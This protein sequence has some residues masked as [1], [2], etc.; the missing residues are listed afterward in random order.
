MRLQKNASAGHAIPI[1]DVFVIRQWSGLP[2]PQQFRRSHAGSEMAATGRDPVRSVRLSD[3]VSARVESWGADQS[4]PLSFSEAIR[5]L[6]ERG[7]RPDPLRDAPI[8]PTARVRFRTRAY[9]TLNFDSL[10]NDVV[11]DCSVREVRRDALIGFRESDE[12]VALC[13]QRFCEC[14][15][16]HRPFD[17]TL[18]RALA[19]ER[20]RLRHDRLVDVICNPRLT[21][22]VVV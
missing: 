10:D 2:Q 12:T 14:P 9:R 7:L 11:L 8:D 5:A 1:D 4:P 16:L 19:V 17:E 18:C 3:E 22:I 20:L 15:Q 6:I 21:I 13:R